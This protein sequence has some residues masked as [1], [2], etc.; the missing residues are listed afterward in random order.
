MPCRLLSWSTIS[1]RVGVSE[2]STNHSMWL[3]EIQ[4][5]C[6]FVFLTQILISFTLCCIIVAISL[7]SLFNKQGWKAGEFWFVGVFSRFQTEM[8]I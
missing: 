1:S 6:S 7:S 4:M 3:S 8:E 5:L 2:R